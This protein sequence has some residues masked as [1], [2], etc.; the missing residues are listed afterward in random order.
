MSVQNKEYTS[1]KTGKT[2]QRYYATVWDSGQNKSITGPYRDTEKEAKLDETDIVRNIASGTIQKRKAGMTFKVITEL[3]LESCAPPAYSNSTFKVYTYYS[4]HFL[5]DVFGD[6]PIN[7]ITPVHI[8]RYVNEIKNLYA[9][10]TVNKCINILVDIFNYSITPLKEITSSPMSGI[11]RVKVP[12]KKREIWSESEIQYFLA[13]PEVKGS[14][15]YAMLCISLLLGSRPSEV[16]GLA[17]NSLQDNPKRL[18]FRRGYDRYGEV[19]DMKTEGSHREILIPDALYKIIHRKLLWKKEQ[20][21]SDLH[22]G[23][24]D[25][26]FVGEYGN[27]IKPDLY[28]K[29]FKRLLRHNNTSVEDSDTNTQKGLVLPDITL[30]GCRHSFA[31]NTL[32]NNTDPSLISSIL[33]NSVK[34][35]L[36]FYAHPNQERQLG[37]LNEYSEK[38]FDKSYENIS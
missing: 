32:A 38:S 14:D 7:K 22:F 19:S 24:N 20:K 23:D 6:K 18:D 25:F 30:Y 5:L 16:C 9:E 33:G 3:W 13:L 26:L 27:P 29:A 8:Q 15:Y 2:K 10:E 31:T 1:K 34:T 4:K 37:L 35:L 17:E 36:T 28:S 11:K 21:L 12:R